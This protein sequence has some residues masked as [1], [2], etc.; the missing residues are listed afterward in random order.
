MFLR[1]CVKQFNGMVVEI[2]TVLP[3]GYTARCVFASPLCVQA[4]NCFAEMHLAVRHL[5]HCLSNLSSAAL[6]RLTKP[7]YHILLTMLNMT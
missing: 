4:S 1:F 6:L 3:L 7:Y 5:A 2:N